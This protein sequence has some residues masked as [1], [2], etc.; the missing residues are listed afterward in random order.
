MEAKTN[1]QRVNEEWYNY[2]IY[3]RYYEY[4]R[5]PY[6]N[7]SDETT[8]WQTE[9]C[10]VADNLYATFHIKNLLEGDIPSALFDPR[11]K[12]DETPLTLKIELYVN[13][14]EVL[15]NKPDPSGESFIRWYLDDYVTRP[16]NKDKTKLD[17]SVRKQLFG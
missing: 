9:R 2:W 6:G 14:Y 16:M 8:Y 12:N 7:N 15:D 17:Q 3:C 5:N 11:I 10:W 4:D 13:F 1:Q